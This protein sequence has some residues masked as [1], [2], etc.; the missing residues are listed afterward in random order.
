MSNE[1]EVRAP[2]EDHDA[3]P[4]EQRPEGDQQDPAEVTGDIGRRSG[5]TDGHQEAAVNGS[6]QSDGAS[7]DAASDVD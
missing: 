3:A 1:N 5:G 7:S 2:A 4:R 6:R